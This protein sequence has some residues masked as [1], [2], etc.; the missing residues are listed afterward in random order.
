MNQGIRRGSAGIRYR[1]PTADPH[2][3]T[4]THT[5]AHD[6]SPNLPCVAGFVMFCCRGWWL[7]CCILLLAC[8]ITAIHTLTQPL[9]LATSPS[10]SLQDFTSCKKNHPILLNLAHYSAHF[11]VFIYFT[12]SDRLIE[13]KLPYHENKHIELYDLGYQSLNAM[14]GAIT[15]APISLNITRIPPSILT[16]QHNTEHTESML[17]HFA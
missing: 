10:S 9:S 11:A 1:L 13:I 12:I 4:H 3:R 17:P 7:W 5:L 2:I 16:G 14:T 15:H 8:I 6:P